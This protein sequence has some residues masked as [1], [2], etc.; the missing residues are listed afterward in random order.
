MKT[1]L[2]ATSLFIVCQFSHVTGSAQNQ[3]DIKTNNRDD[4]TVIR[5]LRPDRIGYSDYLILALSLQTNG[6]SF[7]VAALSV[8][9][10]E[11][12]RLTG[13]LNLGF[14]NNNS[15]RLE[16]YRSELTTYNGHPASLTIFEA[17]END[18]KNIGQSSLKFVLLKLDNG[19][20]QTVNIKMNENILKYH[21][22]CLTQ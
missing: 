22:L 17:D 20:N 7:Y 3:C 19:I 12:H 16:M 10:N 4:G 5:Y 2:I 6:Q 13:T 8:F 1:L 9:Q 15:S 18:L 21:F 14:H 11:A